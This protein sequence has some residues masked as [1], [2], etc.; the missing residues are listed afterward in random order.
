MQLLRLGPAGEERPAVRADDGAVYDLSSV[1]ADIDGDF[2]AGDGIAHARAALG[3]G[4]LER[5][6]ADGLRVGPPVA[7]PGGLVCVGLN[8]LAHAAE[9][10]IDPPAKPVIFLKHPNTIVGPYDEVRIPRG[11][12]RVDWE[13]EL[14]IVIGR[15]A[16]YLGSEDE[17]GDYI[18]GY[19][20]AND[21][22]E[23]AF[24][25]DHSGGQWSKGKCCETF[26][27][28]GPWL[29]PADEVSPQELALRSFVNGEP[30]Q[31]STTADMI[32]GVNHLVWHLSQYLVLE[33]GDVVI[34]GTPEGV[35]LSGRFPFLKAGDVMEMEVEGLGRQRNELVAA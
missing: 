26:N 18:A 24:Q 10:K 6:D 16:R 25:M 20:V 33:P 14:A 7:R 1:T 4:S 21:V 13:V 27:P 12:E 5:L 8:Y 3:D 15:Q 19:T 30:R 9:S 2:L 11:A 22:S 29:V 17:S 32:F 23:R 31:D 35:A 28:L 34:T